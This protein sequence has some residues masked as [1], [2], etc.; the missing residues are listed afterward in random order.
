MIA[1]LSAFTSCDTYRYIYSASP[2]NNPYFIKKGESKLAAYYSSS[3]NS[4]N[5]LANDFAHGYDLQAAYAFSNHWALTSSY[6]NRREK[7][8]YGHNSYNIYDTS[9]IRYKRSLIDISAGYFVSL[10]RKKTISF[11]LY[12][13]MAT[14]KF[15]FTD[16]GLESGAAYSRFHDSRITKWY[17]QPS[18][19]FIPS[20]YFRLSL[21]VKS[22]YV[23]YGHVETSYTP[24][25]QQYFSLDRID[26]K[27][28]SFFE[29]AYNIQ[30]GLPKYPWIKI[31][32]TISFASGNIPLDSRLDVRDFNASIGLSV[33]F[34][35]FKKR[36]P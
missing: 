26:G 24:Y 31:D 5:N 34:S 21:I 23:H 28:I 13:G 36:T 3:N 2:P 25:E 22:A 32:A 1:A 8:D 30:T 10:N 16:N 33:D 14:G 27:T 29:T 4:S 11:N 9:T 7:D 17:F 19:N 15:S 35:K 20:E 6:F 12:G 18:F